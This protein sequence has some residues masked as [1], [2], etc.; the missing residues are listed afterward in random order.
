MPTGYDQ[1]TLTANG[2]EQRLVDQGPELP[3]GGKGGVGES[4]EIEQEW[5][6]ENVDG[7][8]LVGEL[9]E[10]GDP[11]LHRSGRDRANN[12]RVIVWLCVVEN[13]DRDCVPGPLLD[14]LLELGQALTKK[15]SETGTC[16]AALSFTCCAFAI[17][18]SDTM[19]P[20]ADA[21]I[22]IAFIPPTHISIFLVALMLLYK[23]WRERGTN[24]SHS[25]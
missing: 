20:I 4:V 23:S 9:L 6:F 14:L 13:L 18:E 8:N 5:L 15:A 22:R 19:H 2:L 21:S 16:S 12:L 3:V 10:A 25:E 7:G 24:E 1:R 11:K 17:P